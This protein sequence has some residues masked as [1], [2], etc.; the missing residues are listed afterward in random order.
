MTLTASFPVSGGSNGRLDG[1]VEAR[2]GL[3]VDL[4]LEGAL[5]LVAGLV[6]E[7]RQAETEAA[8]RR[9]AVLV[10]SDAATESGALP[11][12]AGL[13][14]MTEFNAVLVVVGLLLAGEGLH[15]SP[16]GRRRRAGDPSGLRRGGL[17]QRLHLR[18]A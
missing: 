15:A 4:R 9:L 12:E 8:S 14:A 5:E 3:L 6:C 17:Q 2:S 16:D 11:D 10:K 7:R 1:A 18:A 13:D